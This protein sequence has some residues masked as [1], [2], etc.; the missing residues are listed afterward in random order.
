MK[1][2]QSTVRGG[3]V[4][5]ININNITADYKIKYEEN[6][7]RYQFLCGLSRAVACTTKLF[8]TEVSENELLE[9]WE[10]EGRECFNKC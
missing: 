4:I 7:H 2:F 5:N 8:D 1:K 6:G 10:A 3:C 9:A